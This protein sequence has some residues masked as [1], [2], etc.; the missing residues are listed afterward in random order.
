MP[1]IVRQQARRPVIG[2]VDAEPTIT[3]LLQTFFE[4]EGFATV[5][6]MPQDRRWGD[7][8]VL[9]WLDAHQP[10]VVLWDISLPYDENWAVFQQVSAASGAKTPFILTTTNTRALEQVMAKTA[11]FDIIAKPYNLDRLLDAVEQALVR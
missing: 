5:A 4:L 3:K 2:I 6:A 1:V 11:D 9:A 8:D 7:L 10:A